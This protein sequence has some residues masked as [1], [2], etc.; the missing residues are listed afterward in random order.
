M[1]SDLYVKLKQLKIDVQLVDGNLDV[2]AP[3]GVL[4]EELLN[5][6]KSHKAELIDFLHA[7]KTKMNDYVDIH[8]TAPQANYVLSS[9]QRRLWVLNQFREAGSAYNIPGVYV[10][11]GALDQAAL[12]YAFA[13]L[14]VRHESLRT[15]FKEDEHGQIRQFILEPAATGF[16]MVYKD[17]QQAG[18]AKVK[19]HV[20]VAFNT[21]FELGTGPLIRA[22]LFQTGPHKWVF[23]YVMHHIISDGWSMEILI[24]ELLQLYNGYLKGVTN[25]LSPL[26]IQYKD[27]AAWQQEQLG[28]GQMAAHKAYWLQQFAEEAPVLALSGD[29]IRPAIKTYNGAAV[30]RLLDTA[31]G[32]DFKAFCQQQGATLYMGLLAAVNA[33]LYRYTSQEDIVIG[34][35]AAGREHADLEDQIGFYINT[36]AMRTRFKGADSF[37]ALLAAVKINTSDAHEHQLFPFDELVEILQP[38]RDLSRNVLFDVWLVLHNAA[39]VSTNTSQELD[40]LKVSGYEVA[41]GVCKFD[42]TFN[43]QEVGET[44]QVQIEYNTDIYT[45]HSIARMAD[46]LNQLVAAVIA[47]PDTALLEIDYLT[48]AEKQQLLQAF[49]DTAAAYPKD[50]TLAAL[51]EAQ[52]QKTPQAPAL[53]FEDLSLSYQEVSEKSTQLGNYL[54]KKYRIKVNDR[55]GI[56]LKRSQ[57]MIIAI[58]GVLKSGG[59]YVPIDPAYPEDR[60]DFMLDDSECKVVIDVHELECF[61]Q[62]AKLYSHQWEGP[63]S[64]PLDLAYVIYT[65]GS[66]G[67]PKGVMIE[68]HAIVNTILAQRSVFDLKGQERGLQFASCSFDASVS[69]IFTILTS[70]GTLY[71]IGEET[72][73]DPQLFE[74]YIADNRIDFATIP[75]AWL[76]MLSIDKLQPIRKLISAGEAAVAA[77]AAAIAQQGTYYNAYGPTEASICATVFTIAAGTHL[78]EEPIPVG[79]PIPN[80]QLYILDPHMNLVPP[81]ITGEIYI[82]GA[83]LAKG[84]LNQAA[85]TAE[86]FVPNPFHK[87]DRIYKTGDLGKWSESGNIVYIGRNDDQV[88]IRG[89]RV[90]LAEIESALNTY[91]N[92][93]AAVVILGTG[94][95]GEK[96]LLAYVTGKEELTVTAIQEYLGNILPAY[97]LPDHFMQLTAF[98]L[99]VNGKVDKRQLQ[100]P[101]GLEIQTGVEYVAPRN[102]TEEKLVQLWEEILD[103]KDIGVKDNFFKVGGHSLKGTLLLTR[104]RKMFDVNLSLSVLFSHPTVE[105]LYHEIEKTYWV[106]D[107]TVATENEENIS[108]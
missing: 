29:K 60:I 9:S 95:N 104:I 10:F 99:T 74:Q 67:Q 49:N 83:G 86:R 5:E 46:H 64:E 38:Q 76:Q 56:Q 98:P 8:K 43:F 65:S 53:V 85:L 97:M 103:R 101:Q 14:L 18:E 68:Q 94:H 6:I 2:L 66:T 12:E 32:K 37:K 4:N 25:V 23:T 92:I 48:A 90:E 59:A 21:L 50:T 57:W 105:E 51:F 55:V 19:E 63:V 11:E 22:S 89:Y 36:A 39:T 71:V 17:L 77:H 106:N 107:D 27:Y 47:A 24:K 96:E 20:Q 73:K 82:G 80:T 15:V 61:I 16:R 84:Y 33:L 78:T 44:I 72:R 45:Q 70:G 13:A 26:R 58:L 7:Y 75:P 52:V 40:G 3:K 41:S 81:G 42:L 93:D 34:S 100:H 62:E 102:E 91:P 35:P 69:E 108:I 88:K 87:G 79:T 28:N 54:R 31:T 30:G 1:L